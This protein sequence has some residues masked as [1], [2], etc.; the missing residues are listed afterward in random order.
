MRYRNRKWLE[1]MIKNGLSL[2]EIARKEGVSPRTI[3]TWASKYGLP[4]NIYRKTA[5]H[6]VLSPELIEF[7]DGLLLG[8]GTI[9]SRFPNT[10]YFSLAFSQKEYLEWISQKLKELGIEQKGQIKKMKGK[11]KQY[12]CWRYESWSYYELTEIRKRWYLKGKKRIPEDIKF[13]PLTGLLWYLGSGYLEI[14]TQKRKTPFLR[15][16]FSLTRY[17][18]EEVENIVK[19]I[20]EATNCKVKINYHQPLRITITP[21]EKFLSFIEPCPEELKP[22]FGKKWKIF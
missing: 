12:S 16:R 14:Q 19:K 13:T 1:R 21:V 9:I 4:T 3:S 10:A 7:F 11:K 8:R 18:K 5:K 22:I 17:S 6:C 20:Q 15:I 2:R